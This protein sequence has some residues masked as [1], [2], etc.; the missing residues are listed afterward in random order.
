MHILL[1][2]QE[3]AHNKKYIR[4]SERIKYNTVTNPDSRSDEISNIVKNGLLHGLR[5]P[6]CAT[7]G[8]SGSVSKF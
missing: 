8:A 2:I 7:F 5:G 4:N 6:P 1:T 3:F